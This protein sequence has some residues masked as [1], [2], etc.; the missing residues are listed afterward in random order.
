[1]ELSPLF[2]TYPFLWLFVALVLGF[3]VLGN[4]LRRFTWVFFVAGALGLTGILIFVLLYDGNYLYAAL[5]ALL[6]LLPLFV[7]FVLP[8]R[9]KKKEEPTA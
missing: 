4:L 8:K 9:E 3:F 5:I 1:M 2:T 6:C 7:F